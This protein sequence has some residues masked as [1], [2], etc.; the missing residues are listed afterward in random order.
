MSE[1]D[2]RVCCMEAFDLPFVQRESCSGRQLK[3]EEECIA[4]F[5]DAVCLL[6]LHLLR[7]LP[8]CPGL[9]VTSGLRHK[10][11]QNTQMPG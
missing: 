8:K 11:G 5:Q 4:T 10:A 9:A 6:Q 2:V 1:F 3:Q 7:E